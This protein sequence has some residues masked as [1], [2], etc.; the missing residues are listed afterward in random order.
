MAT[1]A[2]Y[3]LSQFYSQGKSKILMFFKT[4]VKGSLIMSQILCTHCAEGFP[5]PTV[6]TTVFTH[7]HKHI[8]H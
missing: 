1:P 8:H 3:Y 6:I 7:I 5:S 2:Q 4:T